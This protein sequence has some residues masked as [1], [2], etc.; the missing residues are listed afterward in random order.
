MQ[1]KNASGLSFVSLL[2]F[3]QVITHF[4][5]VRKNP[6]NHFF[7]RNYMAIFRWK[8]GWTLVLL[9]E[10]N[11]WARCG[12]PRPFLVGN[13]GGG[14]WKDVE[15]AARRNECQ[16][17]LPLIRE[18]T[19][20]RTITRRVKPSVTLSC[21]RFYIAH[22]N[23]SKRRTKSPYIFPTLKPTTWWE[24]EKEKPRTGELW[25]HEAAHCF[26]GNSI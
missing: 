18:T 22:H 17:S 2:T 6:F 21:V 24:I 14:T 12:L 26:P 16:L 7:S 19:P 15:R 4:R 3:L 9:V 1:L 10:G 11:A 25:P 8:A 23:T 5:V 20:G 13:P